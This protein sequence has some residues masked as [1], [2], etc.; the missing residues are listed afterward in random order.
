M[1]Y[2][3]KAYGPHRWR[4]RQALARDIA[5][6]IV[7]ARQRG[8]RRPITRYTQDE[9]TT[10]LVEVQLAEAARDRQLAEEGENYPVTDVEH[11]LF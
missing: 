1:R 6:S 8:D 2:H 7:A 9:E 5:A 11:D 3:R 4:S 10:R